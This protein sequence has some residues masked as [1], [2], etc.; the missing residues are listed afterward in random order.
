MTHFAVLFAT[1]IHDVDHSGV[2]NGQ[3]GVEEPHLAATYKEKSI[4]EQNSIDLAWNELSLSKY[5]NLRQCQFATNDELTR[6]RQLTVN[7]V[8][9][10][11]I[12][13][14]DMKALRSRR[15]DKAFHR[16][17]V[18]SEHRF[19]PCSLEEDKNMKATIVIEHI[20]SVAAGERGHHCAC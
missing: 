16:D 19:T 17:A 20:V 15:W 2:S 8:M 11:D 13:E 14:E 6:F 1:L 18:P 10:T 5:A 7:L 12:F 4:A 3:R 9:A